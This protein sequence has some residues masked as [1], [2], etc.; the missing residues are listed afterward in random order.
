[1]FKGCRVLGL[2]PV[3]GAAR[4]PG[5]LELWVPENP[6]ALVAFWARM[7]EGDGRRK[8]AVSVWEGS[9][10]RLN[11]LFPTRVALSGCYPL[12][13]MF[14]LC[15]EAPLVCEQQHFQLGEGLSLGLV[16][17]RIFF[18]FFPEED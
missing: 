13:M 6:C 3:Y 5:Y 15:R 1:M 16:S 17:F 10:S 4:S 9:G 18:F 11:S 7:W 8:R 14:F 2:H 12:C